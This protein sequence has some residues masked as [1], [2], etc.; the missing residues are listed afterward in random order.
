MSYQHVLVPVDGSEISFAAAN[1]AI[2]IAKAMNSKITAI[3]L[4]AEDPFS[5][6]DFYYTTGMLDEYFKEAYANAEKAL[7]QV[8]A[9]AQ[10]AGVELTAKVH[11]ANV[12]ADSLIACTEQLGADLIVMGSHGRKGF[13]K[14]LLGSFAQEILGK[15]TLP[16]LVVKQ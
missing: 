10:Q 12:N 3:C 15:T 2:E 11:K 4:V 14:F 7:A 6:A 13:K 1:Q 5:G 9:A 8:S 16:V